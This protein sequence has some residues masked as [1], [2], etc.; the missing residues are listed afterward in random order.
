MQAKGKLFAGVHDSYWTHACDIDDLAIEL[1]QQFVNLYSQP[2]LENLV[3]EC[4]ENFPEVELPPIP[5]K[6]DMDLRVVLDS[7]YFFS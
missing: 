1:R 6:G 5:P 3:A 4:A 2:I 7:P